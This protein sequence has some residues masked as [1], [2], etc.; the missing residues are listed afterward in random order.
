MSGGWSQRHRHR[1]T[2]I[3]FMQISLVLCVNW[4]WPPSF[5]F[6][7]AWVSVFRGERDL[8]GVHRRV[9][10]IFTS[11]AVAS[12][13]TWWLPAAA[14]LV[15][16]AAVWRQDLARCCPSDASGDASTGRHRCCPCRDL[17]HLDH[18]G[19]PLRHLRRTV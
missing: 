15:A 17:Q 18:V 14:G 9:R 5:L 10:L 19:L 4:A 6:S 7:V 12:D 3:D 8:R 2:P 11:L 13:R 1:T 16:A